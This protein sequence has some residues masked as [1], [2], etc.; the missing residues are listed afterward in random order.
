MATLSSA[1][2]WRVLGTGQPRGLPSMGSHRVG[3][4][5]FGKKRGG[6][7]Y[8]DLKQTNKFTFHP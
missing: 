1:L 2:A 5:P 3:H 8:S 4:D 7:D 6:G